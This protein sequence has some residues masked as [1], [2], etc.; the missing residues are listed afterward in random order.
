MLIRS[1][2]CAIIGTLLGGF[3]GALILGWDASM[4]VGS[5]W[6]GPARD[7]WPL[8]AYVGALAGA[9]F[10]L[11]LGLC[12]SLVQMGVRMSVIA[13]AVIGMIGVI[14]LLSDIS[15]GDPQLRSIPSRVAPLLLSLI[16]WILLGLLLSVVATKLSTIQS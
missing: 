4:V 13:G 7:W 11:C 9:A 8:S 2:V 15:G 14:V 5:T 3:G 12:I 16:V 6:L 10:G 1:L